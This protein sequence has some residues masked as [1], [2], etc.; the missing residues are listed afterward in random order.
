LRVWDIPPSELCRRHLLGEH[1]EVHAVWSIITK[2]LIGYSNHPEV[3]RWRGKLAALYSRHQQIVEEMEGRGYS[4]TSPLD[5]RLAT[6]RRVQL[7]FVNTPEEER[8]LLLWKSCECK[9]SLRKLQGSR[10]GSS[11]IRVLKDVEDISESLDIRE[12]VVRSIMRGLRE[13]PA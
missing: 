2:N 1:A 7:D 4:H 8:R 13:V 11:P 3:V 6:G 5:E 10:W 9:H 12:S